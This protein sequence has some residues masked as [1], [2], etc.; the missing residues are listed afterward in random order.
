MERIRAAGPGRAG[1]RVTEPR[2]LL[3]NLLYDTS[4][5]AIPTDPAHPVLPQ[6]PERAASAG[7]AGRGDGRG[8]IARRPV[9]PHA[10]LPAAPRPLLPGPGPD[11][12]GLP[13][14]DRARQVLVLPLLPRIRGPADGS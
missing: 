6:P 7:R 13:A 12:G 2:T 5:L 4:Q 14:A 8:R 1:F 11:G 3:N 10:R 9:R